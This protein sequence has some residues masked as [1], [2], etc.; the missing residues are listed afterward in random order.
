MIGAVNPKNYK[1]LGLS[2]ELSLSGIINLGSPHNFL[3]LSVMPKTKLQCNTIE[4]VKVKVSNGSLVH[5][6]G[7]VTRIP[8]II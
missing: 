8:F 5:R 2:G 1:G 6:E 7:R 3:D 4:S